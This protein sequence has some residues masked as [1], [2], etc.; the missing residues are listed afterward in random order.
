MLGK[1]SSMCDKYRSFGYAWL[2]LN[3]VLYAIAP[4]LAI[5][6]S[7]KMLTMSFEN[8][9]EL[10][11]RDWYEDATRA[12]GIGMIAAGLAGLAFERG[13]DDAEDD[14]VDVVSTETSD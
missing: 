7:S 10:E 14:S 5:K 12:A 11:P 8:G 4:R 6:L 13:G 9:D 3:G 2:A 1:C